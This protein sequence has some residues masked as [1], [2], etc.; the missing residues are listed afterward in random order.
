[1]FDQITKL[2]SDLNHMRGNK[3]LNNRNKQYER[4]QVKQEELFYLLNTEETLKYK[5]DLHGQTVDQ[6][7]NYLGHYL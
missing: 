7:L 6:S 5:I 3:N 1:M 2:Y 4:I